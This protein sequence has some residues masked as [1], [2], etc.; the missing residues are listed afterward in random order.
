MRVWGRTG[1]TPHPHQNDLFPLCF[2]L[3]RRAWVHDRRD[4]LLLS[5]PSWLMT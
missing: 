5:V 3:S 1:P 2:E 4:P